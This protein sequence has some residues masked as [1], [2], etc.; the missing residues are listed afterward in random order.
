MIEKRLSG[1][2]GHR[3]ARGAAAAAHPDPARLHQ[4]IERALARRDA[5]DFLDFG[6]GGWLVVG[7]DRQGL[8]RSAAQRL[9]VG[10]LAAQEVAEVVGSA[11]RPFVATTDE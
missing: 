4:K 5:T 1:A 7:D 6:A 2:V 10:L 11:E 3:P 9:V 8:E